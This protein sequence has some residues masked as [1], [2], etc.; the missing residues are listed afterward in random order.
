MLESFIAKR[1]LKARR[2]GF[3]SVISIIAILGVVVGVGAII[4]VLSV[5]NGFHTELQHRILGVTPHIIVTRYYNKPIKDYRPLVSKLNQFKEIEGAAPFIYAKTFIKS[6]KGADG[7]LVRGVVPE[8]E[9]RITD[10]SKSMVAGKFSFENDGI[11]LGIE[12]AHNLGV[13]VGDKVVVASP[14][15]F[16]PTPFGNI[17]KFKKYT[18]R[19]IFDS[20]MFDFNAS[21]AYFSLS[22]LQSL[23]GMGSS[24]TGVEVHTKDIYKAPKLAKRITKTLGYPFRALDWITLNKN[25]FAALK[26]EKV[27][28]FIVLTLIVI[29]AAFNII[30]TLIMLVVKKTREIGIL[31]AMGTTSN[32]I[33][34]IFISVGLFIGIIGTSIG[35]GLG[36]LISW[37]LNKYQFIKLPGDVYFIRNLPV[38]MELSDFIIICAA[39]ILIS[40][41]ATIYPARKAAQLPPVEAIRYE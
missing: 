40:F 27:V 36:F 20:G 22:E 4:V 17:P 2:E 33:N 38:R 18:V 19:G 23:L 30:A 5:M 39:A 6:E 37:L 31:K 21:L 3:L 32:E 26:L 10:I 35:A 34:K 41:I 11:V 7:I 12:L 1:Y 14:T 8:M 15:G 25:L 9:Q 24:V 28:T 29:V 16:T 13:W